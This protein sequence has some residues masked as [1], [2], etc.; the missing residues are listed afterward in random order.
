M[1]ERFFKTN[2]QMMADS[3]RILNPTK[4]G[5]KRYKKSDVVAFLIETMNEKSNVIYGTQDKLSK[6]SGIPIATFKSALRELKKAGL[7]KL[8]TKRIMINP[9][10]LYFG[11]IQTKLK[12]YSVY[13]SIGRNTKEINDDEDF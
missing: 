2:R 12:L 4:K 1:Q 8:E 6:R 5:Q 10:W 11:N 13:N 9:D 7:L 3:F